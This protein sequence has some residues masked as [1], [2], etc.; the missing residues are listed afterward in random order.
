MFFKKFRVGLDMRS[1]KIINS[2]V[3]NPVTDNNISNKIYVDI[4]DKFDTVNATTK[5]IS[6]KF[7]WITNVGNLPIKTVLDRLLFPVVN[8][9]YTNPV[10]KNYTIYN[11]GENTNVIGGNINGRLLF[12]ISN[13]TRTPTL[14][15]KLI[16]R[17]NDTSEVIFEDIN[18]SNIID[19]NF[20][21]DN[22]S[23][24]KLKQ[25]FSPAPIQNDSDGNPFVDSNFSTTYDFEY[26][27]NLN[28][29]IKQFN[30]TKSIYSLGNITQSNLDGYLNST[31]NNLK[32]SFNYGN[33]I[34][35]ETQLTNNLNDLN[36][37]LI[38]VHESLINKF[39]NLTFKNDNIIISSS[40]FHISQKLVYN[41]SNEV[42]KVLFNDGYYYFVLMDFGKYSIPT[43]VLLS[44]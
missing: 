6:T 38:L 35:L 27:F 34:T 30:I 11:L 4:G 40:E 7:N 44:F 2:N 16:I 33:L 8:P 15:Y 41:S 36:N 24:I 20:I 22:I 26:S 19:F 18:S 43:N 12:E 25:V 37:I 31:E 14:K 9:T 5:P 23:S 21:W 1:N 3:D 39:C 17:Y 32:T 13:T 10:L 42:C 28:D 29:F